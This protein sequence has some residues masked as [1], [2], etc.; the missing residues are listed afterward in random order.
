MSRPDPPHHDLRQLEASRRR[1]AWRYAL[2]MAMGL[3]TVLLVGYLMHSALVKQSLKSELVQLAQREAEVHKP[4]LEA[5]MEGR[6]GPDDVSI[7]FR[8][9]RTAFY[10]ILGPDARL[11][12]GNETRPALREEVLALLKGNALP[13]GR[14]VFEEIL[15]D[16][17]GALQLA[18]LRHPVKD[19]EGR[20]LGS[21]YAATDVGGSLVHLEQLLVLLLGLALGFVV[22][23]GLG[24]WW[25]ADRSLLP[26]QQALRQQR[27]FIASASHELRAPLTVMNT[28]LAL[29]ER[30]GRE[31]L[32]NFHHQT[33]VDAR[34]EVRRLGR[35]AEELLL[36]ARI[37]AGGVSQR[38]EHLPL[39]EVVQR[40][41]RLRQPQAESRQQSLS[42]TL[43]PGLCVVGD[44]D[45][46]ARL[47]GAGLDNA[48]A[49]TPKYGRIEVRLQARAG[50][51]RLE[52][53]DTGPGMSEAQLARAFE[54]FYRGD[55]SRQRHQAG[56]GLGLAII[57]EVA[58]QHGGEAQLFSRE[59]EGT[60]LVVTLPL[61]I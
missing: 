50:R 32:D 22:L 56:A 19:S 53:V 16:E 55:P 39:D 57:D 45:L 26:L 25:M 46:L 10:Y 21:V 30:E 29:V 17:E 23:A 9:H 2:G 54:R 49:Y 38:H 43:E 36:L 14:V 40:Q 48:V 11:V 4:D 34:D 52:I 5:W 15:A 44:A 58:R 13:R 7:G 12:H 33:L 6:R 60:R 51:A 41:V 61:A 31:R 3:C 37:D 18:L 28:A 24:G 8:P 42:M 27:E 59:G 1:L 35:L 20:Y 47:I